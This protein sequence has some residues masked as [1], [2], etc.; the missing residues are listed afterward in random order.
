M[1]DRKELIISI[2]AV[3][4]KNYGGTL[5]TLRPDGTPQASGVGFVNEG[6]ILYMAMV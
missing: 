1:T 6:P 3:L 2:E 5:A 4:K